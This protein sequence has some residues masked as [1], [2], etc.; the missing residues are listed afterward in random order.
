MLLEKLGEGIRST[1]Q[2]IAK[3]LFVDETMIN[4]LLKDIQRVLLQSDVNV[5]LVYELSKTIKQRV[6]NEKTTGLT[7]KEKLINIVYEEL[8][9][10]LGGESKE[11]IVPI[12]KP[13]KILLVGLYGSGKT[14]SSAKIAKWFSKMGKKVAIMGLDIHRAAA[15]EQIIQLVK[16]TGIKAII[17]NTEKDPVKIYRNSADELKKYDVVIID[18]AGRDAL[19][20]ELIDEI[21]AVKNEVLPDETFL[22][23][24][25][26][27]GQT[28]KVQ[29]D[30]FQEHCG[31]TGVVI[32]KMDGTARGGGALSACAT[33]N[34]PV[35]F[36]STG[37]KI[38]DFETFESKRFV[39]RLLGMGDLTA[40]LEKAQNAVSEDQ[41]KN[42]E[43]RLMKGDFNLIDLYQQMEAMS[44]MGTLGSLLEMV[45][46]MGQLKLPKEA[47]QVQEEK[48]VKW[49]HAMN[50]MTRKELENPDIIDTDRMRRIAS[51]SG[52]DIEDVRTLIKQHRQSKKMVKLLKGDV[53]PEKILKQLKT[54]YK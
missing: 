6:Q 40:L 46:G 32:T 51:G 21:I 54:K 34:A 35:K 52:V 25:A 48:L 23:M 37:E 11:F 29:A 45:P 9:K 43:A 24:S 18:T 27:I 13:A 39:G 1:I 31:I 3:S 7:K 17:D 15:M 49:K 41:A 19:S 28:A 16:G 22:I 53:N 42:M 10:L 8:A 2:K 36:I 38:D 4:E 44:K 5:K 26:D 47:I 12:A 20:R 50:S 33:T 14:T 30:A